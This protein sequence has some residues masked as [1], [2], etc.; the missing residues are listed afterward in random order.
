MKKIVAIV[1]ILLLLAAGCRKAK[2]EAPAPAAEIDSARFWSDLCERIRPRLPA[3]MR[4]YPGDEKRLRGTLRGGVLTLEAESG[5]VYNRFN[6]AEILQRFSD[7]AAELTGRTVNTVLREL[8]EA[9][10]ETRS[11]DELKAFPEARVIG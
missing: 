1:L 7:C 6:R 11:L 3:D 8:S 4:I 5:F 2:T 10:H 9:S